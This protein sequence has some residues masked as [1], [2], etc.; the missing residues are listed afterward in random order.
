MN[1]YTFIFINFVVSFIS[2]IVLNDLANL[3][4]TKYIS[5]IIT[6]LKPYFKNKSIIESGFYAALTICLSLIFTTYINKLIFNFYIP[7]NNIQLFKFIILSFIIGYIIDIL[8]DKTDLFGKSLHPYYKIAGAGFWGAIAF[9][10]SIKISYII[11][12]FLLP[13]L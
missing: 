5:P 9:V 2:D 7:N 3:K 6:S 12:K 10:F 11:Q 4:Q 13:I 1:Y 8:I